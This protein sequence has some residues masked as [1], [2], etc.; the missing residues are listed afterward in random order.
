MKEFKEIDTDDNSTLDNLIEGFQLIG[1]DWRYLYVNKSVVDQSKLKTKKDLLGF[2]MMEKFPGIDNTELFKVLEECMNS[3]V[4]KTMENKFAFPD[5]SFGWYELRIEPVPKGIFILSIDITERKKN[6]AELHRAL[7]VFNYAALASHEIIYDW[8]IDA[9]K[10]WW[11]ENY[12]KLTGE[13]NENKLL[14]LDSRTKFIH[15]EDH[16]Q[17]LKSVTDFLEGKES[18]WNGEYRFIGKNNNVHHLFDRGYLIRDHLGKPLRMIGAAIDISSWKENIN[19]LEQV[20]FSLSHKIRQP[21][22][23]I[24]GISNL[25]ENELIDINELKKIIGYMRESTNS[26][27]KYTKEMTEYVSTNKQKMENKNWA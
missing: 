22:V 21:V 15:P 7:E 26:L 10:V 2:T 24:L 16:D 17:V 25:L 20:L 9:N 23:N 5:G 11:N 12:Y 13:E 8:A 27:D 6:K 3:R 19:Q 14:D 4:S 18:Y 1:F